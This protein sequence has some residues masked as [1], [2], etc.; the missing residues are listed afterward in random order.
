VKCEKYSEVVDDFVVVGFWIGLVSSIF[1]GNLF[2][3]SLVI[4]MKES[5]CIIGKNL[6]DKMPLF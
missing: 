6:R 5:M 1:K 3:G 4:V 2:D